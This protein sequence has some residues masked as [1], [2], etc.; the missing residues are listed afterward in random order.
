[1]EEEVSSG[2]WFSKNVPDQKQPPIIVDHIDASWA[3]LEVLMDR[4]D[5]A[6][7]ARLEEFLKR[8]E[9]IVNKALI[10]R[11]AA[12]AV[13]LTVKTAQVAADHNVAEEPKSPTS[14]KSDVSPRL[15]EEVLE[16]EA[17]E[18]DKASRKETVD[19]EPKTV[20]KVLENVFTTQKTSSLYVTSEEASFRGRLL[21]MVNTVWFEAFFALMII[22]NSLTIGIQV[23]ENSVSTH[24]NDAE[25][26]ESESSVWFGVGIFYTV[27][28]TVELGLRGLAYGKYLFSTEE[29]AWRLV[30]VLVVLTSL[31][32]LSISVMAELMG[33]SDSTVVSNLRILRIMRITRLTRAIRVVRLVRFIRALKTLLYSIAHTL[34]ALVWSLFLL[35]LIIY[36]FSIIFTDA[37]SEFLLRK[38]KPWDSTDEVFLLERFGALDASMDTL[39]AAIT[40]GLTWIEAREALSHIHFLYG[41][42][43]HIYIAFCYFAVLNVM[44]GVF[45]Q[46]AIESAEKD[47]EMIIQSVAHEK[48]KYTRAIRRLF[49]A[50]DADSSGT[51]T[52]EE[53]E[54]HFGDPSI[55]QVFDALDLD[56]SDAYTL[57]QHLDS[58]GTQDVDVQ[59]FLEGCMQLKGPARSIDVVSMKRDLN[60]MQKLVTKEIKENRTSLQ[61]FQKN[62][63]EDVLLRQT[64]GSPSAAGSQEPDSLKP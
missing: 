45:C 7:F 40:G 43:F 57:F 33:R 59:E 34:K 32:E 44:T 39:F 5:D 19:D 24:R 23:Q 41:W 25:G 27:M 62:L 17:L 56:A 55:R 18:E 36:V 4:R 28:F 10:G 14:P 13:P 38:D 49:K 2:P 15:A 9:A 11:P 51:I 48:Q 30:D 47:H 3:D 1:M 53:F 52:K 21:A 64:S 42:V 35:M 12:R 31:I 60:K 20:K 58:D 54:E 22:S 8:Q 63:K 16:E 26:S 6:L 46:S 29:W 50:M 61:S 37:A